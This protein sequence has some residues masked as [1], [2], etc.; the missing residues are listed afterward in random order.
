MNIKYLSYLIFL[1]GIF[2]CNIPKR[3]ICQNWY[4]YAQTDSSLNNDKDTLSVA[5]KQVSFSPP[6]NIVHIRYCI[7][8]KTKWYYTF[9]PDDYWIE[10]YENGTWVRIQSYKGSILMGKEIPS[11]SFVNNSVS[12]SLKE[13]L[14]RF[15]NIVYSDDARIEDKKIILKFEFFVTK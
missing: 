4:E 11:N 12:I 6:K 2:S 3:K 1:L 7:N 14:Y 13:G 10:K 8:N 9:L 15:Y 5:L